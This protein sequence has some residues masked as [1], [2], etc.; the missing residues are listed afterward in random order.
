MYATERHIDWFLMK[1]QHIPFDCSADPNCIKTQTTTMG[2]TR[3]NP[4]IIQMDTFYYICAYSNT[5]FID[6]ELFTERLPE[7]SLCS[8]GFVLDHT[9][10]SSGIVE[11]INNNGY[12]TSLSNIRIQWH[13]FKDNIEATRLGYIDSIKTYT[14]AVGKMI[15]LALNTI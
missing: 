3:F 15:L 2:F 9:R 13:G 5:T 14:Y 8:N 4:N 12:L 6:R 1:S 11:V 7:I 10:P